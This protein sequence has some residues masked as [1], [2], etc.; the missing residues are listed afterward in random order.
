MIGRAGTKAVIGAGEDRLT[1]MASAC[2]QSSRRAFSR[3]GADY[4]G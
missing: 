1:N 2:L 3:C 4:P